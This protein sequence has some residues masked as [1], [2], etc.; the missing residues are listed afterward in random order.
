[1]SDLKN[2]DELF[3]T[4]A[5]KQYPVDENLWAEASSQLDAVYP[6][7]KSNKAWL[8]II[9]ALLM[10]VSIIY[11][12]SKYV[13]NPQATKSEV[14]ITNLPTQ[15]TGKAKSHTS[16]ES[17]VKT[18]DQHENEV[19][20]NQELVTGQLNQTTLRTDQN[21][22]SLHIEPSEKS[23]RDKTVIGPAEI[24]ERMSA[25]QSSANALLPKGPISNNSALTNLDEKPISSAA[26]GQYQTVS[27]GNT[28]PS[29]EPFK[30]FNVNPKTNV[31]LNQESNEKEV[32]TEKTH[33]VNPRL[34][35]W[36]VVVETGYNQVVN[37]TKTNLIEGGLSNEM[38]STNA[39]GL[40]GGYRLGRFTLSTGVGVSSFN[41]R[42]ES[43][44]APKPTLDTIGS[45]YALVTNE[46]LHYEKVVSLIEKRYE[47]VTVLDSNAKPDVSN[48]KSTI[49]YMT[50]PLEIV[51]TLPINRFEITGSVRSTFMLKPKFSHSAPEQFASIM[52]QNETAIRPSL[53][54]PSVHLGVGYRI[55]TNVSIHGDFNSSWTT[56][57]V[58]LGDK[59]NF[60]SVGFKLGV[61]TRF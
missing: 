16:N 51:Y 14:A 60:N 36:Y 55:N 17:P 58:L 54:Q 8:Y 3:K 31:R 57:P 10:S 50:I 28:K 7:G 59:K 27:I 39:Y 11:G 45:Y 9:L 13:N 32:K 40:S 6:V 22:E 48:G 44:I 19:N 23:L 34:S 24:S 52:K 37:K 38:T 61:M 43:T 46:F 53:I 12:I 5:E 20:H 33:N 15:E 56:Q 30:E 21:K 18:S 49:S 42:Y 47:T 1:M 4:G 35:N 2:I 26:Q 29:Y 25:K 41:N